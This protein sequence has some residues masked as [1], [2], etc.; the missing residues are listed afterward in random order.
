MLFE[1]LAKYSKN[2]PKEEKC[3]FR[4]IER[5]KEIVNRIDEA[6]KE[7]ADEDLMADI[8]KRL[9]KSAFDK[10]EHPMCSEVKVRCFKTLIKFLCTSFT[11]FDKRIFEI[12]FIIRNKMFDFKK[13]FITK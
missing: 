9:D 12:L 7:A 2:N 5:S 10:I 11:I 1:N 4:A 3:L 6:I 13:I 8:Q